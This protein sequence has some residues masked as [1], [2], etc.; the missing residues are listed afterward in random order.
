MKDFDQLFQYLSSLNMVMKFLFSR[1]F[2][3]VELEEQFHEKL[4]RFV[5]Q[6]L[7]TMVSDYHYLS[8]ANYMI[9]RYP[10]VVIPDSFVSK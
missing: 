9:T 10:L 5:S 6:P 8:L 4:A 3:C 7:P 1:K 2:L